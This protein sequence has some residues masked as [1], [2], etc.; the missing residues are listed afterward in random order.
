MPL[1]RTGLVGLHRWGCTM[2]FRGWH[3]RCCH[4]VITSLPPCFTSLSERAQTKETRTNDC[5]T[6]S[7]AL[8]GICID[9]DYC[10]VLDLINN[11]DLRSREGLSLRNVTRML[12]YR[13]L[14]QGYLLCAS[15]L[16]ELH[17]KRLEEGQ[18]TKTQGQSISKRARRCRVPVIRTI[19]RDPWCCG[20]S[21]WWFRGRLA[22]VRWAV[23]CVSSPTCFRSVIPREFTGCPLQ[24]SPVSLPR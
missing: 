5:L 4:G 7:R 12:S 21:F 16:M 23:I 24:F 19:T 15:S 14:N 13:R 20:E 6:L 8:G 1:A 9:S 18:M 10:G 11:F 2:G 3:D 17:A 22:G